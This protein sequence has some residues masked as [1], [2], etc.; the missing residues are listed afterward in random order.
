MLF[1]RFSDSQSFIRSSHKL[2]WPYGL[3]VQQQR[4]ICG[5]QLLQIT[6]DMEKVTNMDIGH[7]EILCQI[8]WIFLSL[9]SLVLFNLLSLSN[10]PTKRG[11]RLAFQ[12][13]T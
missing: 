1:A 2:W 3:L 7:H 4:I 8:I 10:T 6:M 13:Y 12:M 5:V 9:C 11:Y